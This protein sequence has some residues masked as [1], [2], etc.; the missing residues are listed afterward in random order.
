MSNEE[1]VKSCPLENE[2]IL[3]ML[4]NARPYS[5]YNVSLKSLIDNYY[6]L[7]VEA[8]NNFE[9]YKKGLYSNH[10]NKKLAFILKNM[11]IENVKS[12]GNGFEFELVLKAPISFRLPF[13]YKSRKE[14]E[15]TGEKE[16]FLVST[17][18]NSVSD[19]RIECLKEALE[20]FSE[21]R[22]SYTFNFYELPY[23]IILDSKHISITNVDDTSNNL[24]SLVDIDIVEKTITF[25]ESIN[26]DEFTSAMFKDYLAIL[27]DC[28]VISNDGS[29]NPFG[30][31]DI[32]YSF[33]DELL[34]KYGL[35]PDKEEVEEEE[36]EEE[37]LKDDVY[38]LVV[39]SGG[40]ELI[41][42]YVRIEY[43]ERSQLYVFTFD[44]YSKMV[45]PSSS[46]L[47]LSGYYGANVADTDAYN[48]FKSLALTPKGNKEGK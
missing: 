37:L 11:T 40:Y 44:D 39:P 43:N 18:K 42:D 30:Y 17:I 1:T 22:K 19:K 9:E 34:D 12:S 27:L 8:I 15:Y 26:N 33:T 45:V 23:A 28:V 25:N 2:K 31:H 20:N 3:N 32:N 4:E 5:Y 38:Y 14:L 24:T 7:Y 36:I 13:Y 35:L 29:S 47:K 41:K 48:R 6:A 16:N 46:I 21:I 10:N